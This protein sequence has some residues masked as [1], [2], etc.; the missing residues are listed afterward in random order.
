L[1]FNPAGMT[2]LP[3]TQ[4][5]AGAQA[6][7]TQA[8]FKTTTATRAAALGASSLG[9]G[10]GGDA[11]TAS[12]VPHLYATH[13]LNDRTWLGFALNVP[14]GL[15]T[16][17]DDGWV[18]RYHALKSEVLTINLNPSIAFKVSDRLS[19]G[20]GVSAQYIDAE[21]SNAIDFGAINVLPPPSG[22]GGGIPGVGPGTADGKVVLKGDD[23]GFGWNVGALFELSDR[24]RIGAHY[25]SEVEQNLEGTADFSGAI[26]Q[27]V[28]DAIFGGTGQRVLADTGVKSAVD[29]PASFSLSVFHQLS[30]E[31]SVMAD[32]T[33]TGWSSLKELRFDFANDQADGVTTL[34]WG[35]SSR[36]SIGAAYAPVSSPWVF[37]A[38]VA[39]DETPIPNAESRTPRI[40]GEDRLWVT[41][42][43]SYRPSD[44]LSI[45]F[46]YAH[47]FVDDPK[48]NKSAGAP[49]DEDFLRGSLQGSYDASTDIVSAQLQY[50]Y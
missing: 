31:W 34:N 32:Y 6:V 9:T 13:Q 16:E 44:K 27:T 22:L 46:G 18:G 37:R 17:Y 41:L 40:P 38:G 33:W 45:D 29:L 30:S 14:F 21:L 28:S 10:D 24:T 47:L 23:W 1:Y 4:V 42:G 19:L 25:R 2:R 5:S 20:I 7:I 49:G 39:L 11:G 8:K 15:S 43:T 12:V 48:I 50:R 26:Q 35:D 36:Y 3:G